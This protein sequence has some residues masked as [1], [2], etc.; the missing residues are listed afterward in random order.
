MIDSKRG[1]KASTV[2]DEEGQFIVSA[3]AK[4]QTNHGKKTDKTNKGHFQ[5]IAENLKTENNC[6][7]RQFFGGKCDQEEAFLF[8]SLNSFHNNAAKTQ[9]Q[10]WKQQ[11]LDIGQHDPITSQMQIT[12]KQAVAS[13]A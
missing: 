10:D 11:S 7:S 4:Q 8:D 12:L 3:N 13:F 6:H 5:Y 1:T 2:E 9:E